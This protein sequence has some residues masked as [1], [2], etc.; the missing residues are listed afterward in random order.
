MESNSLK[1]IKPTFNGQIE[2]KISQL[3]NIERNMTDVK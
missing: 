3:G 2:A 1:I